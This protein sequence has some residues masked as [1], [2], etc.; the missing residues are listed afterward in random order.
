MLGVASVLVA[1]GVPV[2]ADDVRHGTNAG[3]VAGCREDCC[4]TA[5]RNYHKRLRIEHHRGQRRLISSL[6]TRRRIEALGALGWTGVQVGAVLGITGEHVRQIRNQS[7]VTR[8]LAAR[9]ATA[10]DQLSMQLPPERTRAER[11]NASRQRNRAKAAGWLPPLAWDDID[12]SM[13][14]GYA[15]NAVDVLHRKAI[16]EVVVE[17]ILSGRP[18]RTA[19]KAERDEVVARWPRTGRSLAELA[20]LTGWKVERYGRGDAA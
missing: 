18:C 12:D 16:D 5:T 1:G 3:Y 7:L 17:R 4:R 6:G 10:Y 20:R 14:A 8:S 13:D 11:H 2:R 19:T 15:R 9:V